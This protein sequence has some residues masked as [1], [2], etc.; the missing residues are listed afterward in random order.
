MNVDG[1]K[2]QDRA[3]SWR[4]SGG[5]RESVLDSS[6]ALT[7]HVIVATRRWRALQVVYKKRGNVTYEMSTSTGRADVDEV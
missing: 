7:S 5:R 4:L 2:T 1:E 6:D 3:S